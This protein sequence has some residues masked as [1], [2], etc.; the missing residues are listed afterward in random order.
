VL[1]TILASIPLEMV[2]SLVDKLTTKDAWDSIIATHIGIDHVRHVTLQKLHQEWDRLTFRP[3][4]DIDDFTLYL[5][6]LVQQ[7][8]WHVNGEVPSHG[9]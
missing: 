2:S 5:F 8:A 1:N 6:G 3:R 9:P 4:D 7:H